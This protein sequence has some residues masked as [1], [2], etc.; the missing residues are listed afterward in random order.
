MMKKLI[1]T[2]SLL[3]IAVLFFFG[4]VSNP[5]NRNNIGSIQPPMGYQ[6]IATDDGFAN[7]LRSLPLKKR[8]TLV[9]LHDDKLAR[10]QLLS[11]AVVDM[12]LLGSDEQCADVCMRLR[13]E[14][15]W[16]TKRY[17]SISFTSVGGDKINYTSGASR[18]G[19]EA[20]MRH[21][22]GRCNTASLYRQTK[23][24]AVKD[25]RPGDVFVYPARSGHKYGHALIVVDVA[26]NKR[27]GAKALLIAEGNT[28]ARNI[29]LLRNL[30][31][32]RNPWHIVHDDDDKFFFSLFHFDRENL[33]RF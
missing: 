9:R 20:Y 7:Y 29:H 16:G 25:I 15:L 30:N 14:Y 1:F 11:T 33:R 10:Y 24:V 5:F 22:Y 12:P 13:A 8:G 27:T 17:G 2:I 6:R 32:A 28:P 26:V 4:F 3:V 23:Q 21:V 19:F 31:V 18:K